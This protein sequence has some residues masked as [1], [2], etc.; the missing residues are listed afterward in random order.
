M[1]RS[2]NLLNNLPCNGFVIYS[3][4]ISVVGHQWTFNSPLDPVR[5]RVVP[6]VDVLGAFATRILAIFLEQHG[7]P[8]VLKQDVLHSSLPLSQQ[9]VP[10]Q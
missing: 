10:A 5:H 4:I 6:N 7:I 9:K 2:L 1:I 3:A 8:V